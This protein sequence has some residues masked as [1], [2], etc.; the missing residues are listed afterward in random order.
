LK[1]LQPKQCIPIIDDLP[2]ATIARA[3]WRF[4]RRL[5]LSEIQPQLYA[6]FRPI[7]SPSTKL[8]IRKQRPTRLEDPLG[9][10]NLGSPEVAQFEGHGSKGRGSKGPVRRVRLEGYGSKGRG[11]N[12]TARKVG[13]EGYG[14][15]GT[16][17]SPYISPE[18][19]HG[20]SQAAERTLSSPGFVTGHDFS[21]AASG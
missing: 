4:N 20:A 3:P 11:S 2:N 7:V 9:G 13:L 17:F 5:V 19:T 18:E 14:S 6:P 12:G 1:I 16:G 10:S 21:R 15:K 8:C